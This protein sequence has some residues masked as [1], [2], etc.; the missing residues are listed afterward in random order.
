M[1]A[2]LHIDTVC[3]LGQGPECCSYLIV[4]KDG[5]QCAKDNPIFRGIIKSRREEGTIGA[6]G[7]GCDGW[8]TV[9]GSL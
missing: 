7:D 3:K 5:F 2:K 6:M 9:K 1:I 8:S 4:G